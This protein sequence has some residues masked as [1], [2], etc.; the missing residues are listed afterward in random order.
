MISKLSYCWC[1]QWNLFLSAVH[2][3][4]EFSLRQN[5][6]AS[7]RNVSLFLGNIPE[8]AVS[9][10]AGFFLWAFLSWVDY[11]RFLVSEV[12]TYSRSCSRSLNEREG[13]GKVGQGEGEVKGETGKRKRRVYRAS[14]SLFPYLFLLPLLLPLALPFPARLFINGEQDLKQTH[15][16]SCVYRRIPD[17]NNLEFRMLYFS[18]HHWSPGQEL[19]LA[20]ISYHWPLSDSKYQIGRS[21]CYQVSWISLWVYF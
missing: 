6:T 1:L 13:R 2:E 7:L 4:V 21:S 19:L 16:R 11:S 12:W 20:W 5:I 9:L 8:F 15:L 10:A 3:L 17:W 18:D 14:P